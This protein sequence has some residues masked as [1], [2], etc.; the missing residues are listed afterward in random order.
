MKWI[1]ITDDNLDLLNEGDIAQRHIYGF[2][3]IITLQPDL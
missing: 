2:G 3:E 1:K